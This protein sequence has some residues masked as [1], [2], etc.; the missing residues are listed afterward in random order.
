[1][2]VCLSELS[3]TFYA[4]RAVELGHGI[5]S[6]CEHGYQ[7]RYIE[8]YEVAKKYGLKFLESVEAY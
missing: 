4:K 2:I 6:S 3:Q 1:M 7:G 5:L 8:A